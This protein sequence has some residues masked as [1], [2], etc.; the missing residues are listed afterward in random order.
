[1]SRFLILRLLDKGD[2]FIQL[3]VKGLTENYNLKFPSSKPLTGQSLRFADDN[4]AIEWVELQ[5]NASV[6]LTAIDQQIA[7]NAASIATT[8]QNLASLSQSV[9]STQQTLASKEDS[10]VAANLLAQHLAAFSHSSFITTTEFEQ[11]NQVIFDL[12]DDLQS[13]ITSL[14]TYATSNTRKTLVIQPDAGSTTD[15]LQVKSATGVIGLR[16]AF[17][18][19]ITLGSTNGALGMRGA[20]P[21][22][23]A[24]I[25][26]SRGGNTALGDLLTKL[27]NQ[28][29]FTN[30]T[31]A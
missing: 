3:F 12:I 2:K 25:T 11:S 29:Y 6:D 18:G 13:Q 15:L 1:M 17:D 9:V 22:G 4:G 19:A 26:G 8:N 31:S 30:N 21:G 10:G 14:N 23:K 5:S 24:S 16:V 20:T 7:A 27:G 28:G